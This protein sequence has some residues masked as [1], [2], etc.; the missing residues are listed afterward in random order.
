MP[1]FSVPNREFHLQEFQLFSR[2]VSF[3]TKGNYGRVYMK[4]NIIG[5]E[6]DPNLM[7]YEF[8]VHDLS[9]LGCFYN[10]SLSGDE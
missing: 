8:S 4:F 2:I 10:N 7:F 5:I 1:G 6:F 3:T 9:I